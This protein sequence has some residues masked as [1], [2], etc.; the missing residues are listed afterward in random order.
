MKQF[1][2]FTLLLLLLGVW[3][4]DAVT[5]IVSYSPAASANL[6]QTMNLTFA[7]VGG[8]CAAGG[9][10]N[11][12]FKNTNSS[13]VY[14]ISLPAS[15]A[16]TYKYYFDLTNITTAYTPLMT[17]AT[18]SFM[19]NGIYTLDLTCYS[20]GLIATRT[21]GLR[22]LT[23]CPANSSYTGYG[24]TPISG[25]IS[26]ANHHGQAVTPCLNCTFG[27]WGSFCNLTRLACRLSR[28]SDKGLCS[29]KDTGCNCDDHTTG[30]DCS[31]IKGS[32][33]W[34][35]GMIVL[36]VCAPTITLLA[37]I[38]GYAFCK[39]KSTRYNQVNDG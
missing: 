9:G 1:L 19:E 4:T 35:T 34:D 15:A 2:V 36:I 22:V 37:L 11:A 38:V 3:S 39:K 23:G 8:T 17:N 33:S 7:I 27:W 32:D 28:C 20:S 13:N 26:C 10:V 29:G 21:T 30:S 18:T 25:C 5:T 6:W 16:G 14:I 12:R 24:G 31:I